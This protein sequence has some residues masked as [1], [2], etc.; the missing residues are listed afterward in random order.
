MMGTY[1]LQ[2]VR[3]ALEQLVA[4]PISRRHELVD[5]F[6]PS[7]SSS[8]SSSS[9]DSETSASASTALA[10]ALVL[11][12]DLGLGPGLVLSSFLVLVLVLILRSRIP[13]CTIHLSLTDIRRR[14]SLQID[15]TPDRPRSR[16]PRAIDPP[17]LL[18]VVNLRPETYSVLSTTSF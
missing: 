2:P 16:L 18:Y 1:R 9:S 13:P 15:L 14:L 7:A 11:T 5:P 17:Q 10:L 4:R 3:P 12:Y 6:N 8:S